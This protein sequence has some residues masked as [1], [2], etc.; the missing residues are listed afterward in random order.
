MTD[1]PRVLLS[2]EREAWFDEQIALTRRKAAEALER[3][4]A[5]VR[6]KEATDADR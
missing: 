6:R 5:I 1:R 4:E 2:P 3:A